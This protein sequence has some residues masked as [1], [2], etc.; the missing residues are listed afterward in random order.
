MKKKNGSFKV[1]VK[2]D[3]LKWLREGSG[4]TI[5]ELSKKIGVEEKILNAWEV[6]KEDPTM[7]NLK[8]LSKCFKRPLAAFLLPAPKD[9]VPIP[10]EFRVLPGE[11]EAL[12]KK[13][14]L[15]LRKARRLQ[16]ISGELMGGININ[17]R[18]EAGKYTI[19]DNPEEVAEIE[20]EKLGI[21]LSEQFK[22]WKNPSDALKGWREYIE[23]KRVMIFQ[24]SMPLEDGRGFSLI[25]KEPH[26]IVINSK[27]GPE[28]RIF[29][30]F[31]EYGH[32]L[33]REGESYF[34][35]TKHK[36]RKSGTKIETWCNKFSAAFLMPKGSVMFELSKIA[37]DFVEKDIKK[38]SN[39]YKVSKQAMLIRL[40]SLGMITSEKYDEERRKLSKVRKKESSGG[41]IKPEKKPIYEKGKAF[42]SLV[43]SNKNQGKITTRDA[44][45]YLSVNLKN[46][47]KIK[48]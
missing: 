10:K 25:D 7:K 8:D 35:E 13:T 5:S 23:K 24:F 38:F 31:H 27:D 47:K 11:T 33:L 17:S 9:D 19:N 21:L 37:E 2:L 43:M 12:S 20:R 6:G 22:K 39:L 42:V 36:V 15:V 40:L 34:F 29:T 3:V 16:L 44:L 32:I 4:Y 30:L 1:K 26:T 41:F 45:N 14:L 48:T 28:A 46:I 18:P